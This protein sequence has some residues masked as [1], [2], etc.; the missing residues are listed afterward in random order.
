MAEDIFLCGHVTSVSLE[1][2]AQVVVWLE[3]VA[4]WQV[5]GFRFCT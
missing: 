5:C 3:L 4:H 1:L 2:E